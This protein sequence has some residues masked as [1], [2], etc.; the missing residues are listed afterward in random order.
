VRQ[1]RAD[2]HERQARLA[3]LVHGGAQRGHVVGPEV[4]HLVEEDRHAAAAVARQAADV[5]EQLDEVDLHVAGV[6]AARHDR[7][8]D[9][10]LPAVP[11]LGVGRV[12]P[13]REGLE[14]AE[15]VLGLARGRAELPDGQ[16]QRGGERPAQRLL[17][18]C[19]DLARAPAAA[20]RL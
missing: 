9:A 4:L 14:H 12:V 2:D 19:F 10:R 1:A 7:H 17:R 6:R 16:V 15:H 8:V 13:Q 5:H 18:P 3:D 20:H 11:D